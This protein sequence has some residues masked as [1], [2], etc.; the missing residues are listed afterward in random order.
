MAL[1]KDNADAFC[2]AMSADFGNRS[3]EQSLLTDI[4]ATVGAG[5]HALIALQNASALSFT[6]AIALRMRSLR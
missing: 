5:K 1:V 3:M 2:K 6:R 4:G